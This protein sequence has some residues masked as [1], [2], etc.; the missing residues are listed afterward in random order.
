VLAA[1][2]DD[3]RRNFHGAQLC[4][5]SGK[6]GGLSMGKFIF[7]SRRYRSAQMHRICLHEYGHCIQSLILGPLY[8]PVVAIP[9][10]LWCNL[11]ACKSYRAKNNVDYYSFYTEKWADRLAYICIT[12]K[13]QKAQHR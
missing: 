3:P 8:L 7:A 2:S 5:H 4:V 1:Y 9:S 11:P 6:F 12:K 10:A 13:S